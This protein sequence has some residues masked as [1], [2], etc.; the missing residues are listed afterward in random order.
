MLSVN[1]MSVYHTVMEAYN[2]TNRT[3]SEQLQKKLS[4]HEGKHSERS[5]ANNEL[6]V[7]K[8]TRNKCTGFSYLGHKLYNILTTDTKNAK[9][10]DDFKTKLMGWIWKNIH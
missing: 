6:Y 3:A 8:K 1:Q 10:I 9:S 5:A 7:P 2:I 4:R